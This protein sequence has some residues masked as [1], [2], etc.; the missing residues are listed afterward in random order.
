MSPS[1]NRIKEA[2]PPRS[3][4]L[5]NGQRSPPIRAN[6]QRPPSTRADSQPSPQTRAVDQSLF[7]TIAPGHDLGVNPCRTGLLKKGRP[8]GIHR[9]NNETPILRLVLSR[10]VS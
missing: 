3:L 2:P 10:V 5:A 4:A 7:I 9:P 8:R 6:T 1:Y